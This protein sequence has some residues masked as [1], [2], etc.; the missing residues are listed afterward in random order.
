MLGLTAFLPTL[1]LRTQ[2]ESASESQIV[3]LRQSSDSAQRDLALA[4]EHLRSS[5]AQIQ[6]LKR[7]ATDQQRLM[8]DKEATFR[9][10]METIAPA[11]LVGR[12]LELEFDSSVVNFEFGKKDLTCDSKEKLAKVVGFLSR[13]L[14]GIEKITVI[15]HTDKTGSAEF[16]EKLSLDRAQEVETYLE[17][18]GIPKQLLAPPEGRSF[19]QP[20]G[21]SEDAPFDKIQ[22]ENGSEALKA[23]N[24]RV[25][26]NIL[27]SAPKA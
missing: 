13:D 24:R 27:Q 22:D 16:N 4:Q 17:Q 12:T 5:A 19:R 6:D 18:S 11:K 21:Y 2:R 1:L 23:R 25:Q 10:E 7:S 26:M 8:A 15:G 9:K 14:A 3:R 20:F